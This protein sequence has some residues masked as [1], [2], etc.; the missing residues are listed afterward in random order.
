MIQVTL[1]LPI[2]ADVE[3]TAS[4]HSTIRTYTESF[5]RVAKIGWSM[6]R[7]NGVEL[8]K[9][10]YYPE[11]E[12]SGLPSQLVCSVQRK[13]IEAVKSGKTK[14]RKGKKASCPESKCQAI[15][16]DVNSATVKL[17][18]GYATLATINGRVRVEFKVPKVF[19][20][21]IA[22][23]VCSSDLWKDPRNGRLFLCVVV[24]TKEP[25]VVST[26][27]VVGVD[28]GVNR[29]A[30]TSNNQFFGKRQWKEIEV[31]TARLKRALQAKGTKSAKRHLKL[32]GRKVNG[33]RKD[34]DHVISKK[35]I[36]N[37]SKGATI[38]L[39][40]LTDIRSRVKARKQQRRRIHS[41]SFA[42]LQAFLAYKAA[43]KGV[44]V[45]YIDP[46]YTSQKCSVCGHTEKANRKNQASFVCKKCKFSLNADLN[47]A[48][49]IRQNHIA[50]LAKRIASGLCV[51]Q[52]NVS[53][54]VKKFDSLGTSLHPCGGGY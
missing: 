1:K 45:A 10:V 31:R 46:R 19:Q 35:L 37:C 41:W 23:K 12:A 8:H 30:V 16:Y 24:E 28:L 15:R 26:D 49:N 39:E 52:P 3:I 9:L 29:P 32:L 5:N 11:R 50:N 42:R 13:A 34:C 40:D 14:L 36:E 2:Q 27:K 38:V 33:F 7:I 47:A 21:R 18:A 53:S 20:D 48:R 22:W 4:L 54:E 43:M 17:Q 51:N 25:E 6:Q 44:N